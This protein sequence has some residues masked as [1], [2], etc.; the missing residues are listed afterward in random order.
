MSPRPP[1]RALG[2]LFVLVLFTANPAQAHCDKDVIAR[3]EFALA[4]APSD[5]AAIHTQE[6]AGDQYDLTPAAEQFCPKTYILEKYSDHWQIRFTW[7]PPGTDGNVAMKWM[8][9]QF[10]PILKPRGFSDKPFGKQIEP[11]DENGY[12][13]GY[14]IWWKGPNDTWVD[15]KWTEGDDSAWVPGKAPFEITVGHDDK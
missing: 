5:F 13:D 6:T 14:E 10:S 1:L 8:I 3:L 11:E 9:D 2:L 12:A 15:V 7:F 4:N